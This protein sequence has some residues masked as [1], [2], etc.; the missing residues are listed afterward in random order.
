MKL[1]YNNG[2]TLQKRYRKLTDHGNVVDHGGALRCKMVHY[3]AL[4]KR[5]RSLADH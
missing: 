4:Q 1:P 3:G 5:C 2:G